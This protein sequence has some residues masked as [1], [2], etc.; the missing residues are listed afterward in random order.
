[1]TIQRIG[2]EVHDRRQAVGLTQARLA[3]LADLSRQTVQ[4]LEAGTIQDLSFQRLAKLLS[5]LGLSFDAP[6][7]AARKNK[8]G[9]WM[10]A[11]TSSVSY[12]R[13]L[14]SEQLE[15]ALTSG[16]VPSGLESNLLHFLDEAPVE[17]VVMAVEEAA[18][19][20]SDNPAKVWAN[21]ARLAKALG[22]NRS[23]LW[24]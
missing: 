9:L 13:E 11:K 14:G 7:T 1:M 24:A 10:A 16:Q 15:R 4:R 5:V 17:I 8:R 18:Q 20:Q 21:V 12:R 19:R 23:D 6:S 22:A 3:K 2:K